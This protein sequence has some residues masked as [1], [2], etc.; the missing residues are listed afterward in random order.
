[1][2]RISVE[3]T[4]LEACAQRMQQECDNYRQNY[5]ALMHAV[6]NMQNSWK[7][8]D[9]QAFTDAILQFENDFMQ[10]AMLVEQYEAFLRNSAGAYRDTQDEITGQAR[11]LFHS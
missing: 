11:R 4:E 1:M 7:G 8:K 5:Q 10:V 9:N 2:S 6:E 3:P